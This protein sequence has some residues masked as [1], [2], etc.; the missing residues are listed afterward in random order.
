LALGGT[1]PATG[2]RDRWFLT[3]VVI[4]AV[5]G[6]CVVIAAVGRRWVALVLSIVLGAGVAVLALGSWNGTSYQA[7][8]QGSSLIDRDDRPY[9]VCHSGGTCDCPGG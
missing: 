9:C 8:R 5:L 7:D 2:Q 3:F 6:C 1:G 4:A